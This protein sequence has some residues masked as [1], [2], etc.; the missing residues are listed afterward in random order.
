[1][2]YTYIKRQI[3]EKVNSNFKNN[4][5]F[6]EVLTYIKFLLTDCVAI[7]INNDEIIIELSKNTDN[8]QVAGFISIKINSSSIKITKNLTTRYRNDY[9][10][11]NFITYYDTIAVN[12]D[13]NENNE[14]TICTD[15]KKEND[16]THTDDELNVSTEHTETVYNE[17]GIMT[18]EET[19]VRNPIK[20]KRNETNIIYTMPVSYKE[21]LTR[22]YIDTA[23]LHIET[24]DDTIYDGS[25]KVR[26]CGS[27]KNMY[28]AGS[29]GNSVICRLSNKEIKEIIDREPNQQV[30]DGLLKLS[31]GRT[32]YQYESEKDPY[33][34]SIESSGFN[35]KK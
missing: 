30:R 11:N 1:M 34:I 19:S 20:L 13:Y 25:V 32:T 16:I 31:L 3:L 8:I 23:R 10:P 35:Q 18:K 6:Y 2:F 24:A 29:K 33:F 27:A 15:Y 4:P 9:Y 5:A 21:T 7:K 26:F 22:Q 14:I 28:Y 12:I 17:Y